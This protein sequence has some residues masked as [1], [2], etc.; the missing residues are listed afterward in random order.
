M[1][2]LTTPRT[3]FR[4]RVEA[5]EDRSL[6]CTVDVVGGTMT[7]LGDGSGESIGIRDDGAGT[8]TVFCDGA[9]EATAAGI[10]TILVRARGGGDTVDY[11]QTGDRT[12]D[13]N[14][15][16]QLGD[17]RDVFFADIEGDIVGSTMIVAVNGGD[18]G[19]VITVDATGDADGSCDPSD[20]VDISFGALMID[21]DGGRGLGRDLISLDYRGVLD[22]LLL[23]AE[24]GHGGRDDLH[25][26]MQ[27]LCGSDG[28]LGGVLDGG[29]GRDRLF[30]HI[31]RD[32]NPCDDECSN[33]RFSIALAVARGGGGN[34]SFDLTP[35]VRRRNL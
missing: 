28:V 7:I 34:D 6:L 27:V 1:K 18:K 10:H 30:Y 35:N 11:H 8:V 12:S 9:P 33:D 23:F 13:M 20:G 31:T 24:R 19:D 21:L 15:N 2:S 26:D 25:A 32:H 3:S 22:G 16:V 29:Q 4:P 17:G 5:L 14:L